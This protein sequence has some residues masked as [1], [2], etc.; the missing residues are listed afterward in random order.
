MKGESGVVIERDEYG[1]YVSEVL[2]LRGC[3]Y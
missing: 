3:Y 2:R 1:F